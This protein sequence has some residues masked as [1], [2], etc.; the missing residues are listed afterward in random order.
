MQPG[1]IS[2]KYAGAAEGST[3]DEPSE[4]EH[5]PQNHGGRSIPIA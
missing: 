5:D 1:A 3:G 2:G 4:I